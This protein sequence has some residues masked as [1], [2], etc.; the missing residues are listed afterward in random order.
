MQLINREREAR[1][2][3]PLALDP[4]LSEVARA[5]SREMAAKGYFAHESPTPGLR[6][7]MERYRSAFPGTPQ[8][9]AVAENIFYS[10]VVSAERGHKALMGSPGHRKNILD[11]RFEAVGIGTYTNPAGEY[12]VT[13]MFL[14]RRG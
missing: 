3:R 10:S 13:Q 14:K 4:E 8:Y 2:L 7:P 5:H 6:T 12:W 11:G 1:G 9:L